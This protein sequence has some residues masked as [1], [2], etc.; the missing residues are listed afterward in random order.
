MGGSELPRSFPATETAPLLAAPARR[1]G[2]ARDIPPA[3]K[4]FA[5]SSKREFGRQE[6][7]C[8]GHRLSA[9]GGSVDPRKAQSIVEWAM[10]ASCTEARRFTGLANYYRRFV[11]VGGYAEAVAA[12]LTALGGPAVRS[13]WS[14]GDEP[15]SE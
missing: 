11:F 3:R 8:P 4:P 10:P 1:G 15:A 14:A 12:P 5:K 13:A 7:G 2:G 6:L 9:E